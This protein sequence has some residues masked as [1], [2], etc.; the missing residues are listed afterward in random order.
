MRKSQAFY[1]RGYVPRRYPKYEFKKEGSWKKRVIFLF[2]LILIFGLAYFL[3]FSQVFQIKD[4]KISGNQ[5]IG[6]EEIIDSLNNFIFKK[7]L[8]FFNKNNIFLA[9]ESKLKSVLIGDFPRILSLE[10]HKNIFKQIISLKI[11]ER[12]EAGIFCRDEC[13][14]I[15]KDGVIFEKA[16]DTSGTLILVIR[17]N[18]SE[19][20]KL[21][22]IVIESKFMA[23]IVGVRESLLSQFSLKVL[24]FGI[25]QL[26]SR[27]LKVNT[28]EGWY[29]LLDYSRDLKSQLDNLKLVLEQ[30]IKENRKNLEY[31]DLR[32]ENRIYY[33]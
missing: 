3:F 17:D 13:Y 21:G 15:D 32:I 26:P 9:T 33:K 16:P 20:V 30:K 29:I 31:I 18:S 2:F 27:D 19:S 25:D 24:D 8:Y 4:I 5:V 10:I 28:H 6:N 22:D 23:D 12:K 14:Y 1:S 7:I 11:V